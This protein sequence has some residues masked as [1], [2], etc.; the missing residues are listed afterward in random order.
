[1]DFA[2]GGAGFWIGLAATLLSG[3]FFVTVL[4]TGLAFWGFGAGLV[5]FFAGAGLC[6]VLSAAFAGLAGFF[7]VFVATVRPASKCLYPMVGEARFRS[8]SPDHSLGCP[9]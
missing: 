9:P 4:A 5:D 1:M 8:R 7:A 3:F 6:V 2:A